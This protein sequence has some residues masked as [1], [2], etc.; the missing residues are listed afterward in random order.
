LVTALAINQTV[1]VTAKDAAGNISPIKPLVATG[2]AKMMFA[3]AA[4]TTDVDAHN[5]IVAYAAETNRLSDSGN[6]SNAALAGSKD[7]FGLTVMPRIS[8]KYISGGTGINA[9]IQAMASFEPAAGVDV[10]N[11]TVSVDQHQIVL[12]VGS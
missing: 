6:I 5:T 1:N 12:T 3:S 8:D 10:R 4:L 7:D 11:R 9:L 2:V